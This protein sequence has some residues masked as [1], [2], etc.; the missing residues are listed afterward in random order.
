MASNRMIRWIFYG[1]EFILRYMLQT[2]PGLVPEIA[3]VRPLLLIPAALS[4]AMFEGD[5]GGMAAGIVAG[6][7][8]DLSGGEVLGFYAALLAVFGFILGS[9]TM[10]LFRT[11]L[12]LMSLATLVTVPAVLTLQWLVFYLLPGYA[13]GAYVY[14]M[15]YLP[16]MIYTVVL[17]PLVYALNRMI[18]LRLSEMREL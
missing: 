15:H 14:R 16:E 9:M 5:L 4:V 12:L 3:G 13:G 7:F 8:L 18:A 17:A 6:L 10:E 11:N 2:T 1:I